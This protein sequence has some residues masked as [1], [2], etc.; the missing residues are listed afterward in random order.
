MQVDDSD[1]M[2]LSSDEDLTAQRKQR[3]GRHK[4]VCRQQRAIVARPA[5]GVGAGEGAAPSRIAVSTRFSASVR[6]HV[7]CSRWGVRPVRDFAGQGQHTTGING[8]HTQA[9]LSFSV[10]DFVL[11]GAN[12]E[13]DAESVGLVIGIAL[14]PDGHAVSTLRMYAAAPELNPAQYALKYPDCSVVHWIVQTEHV[15]E[16]AC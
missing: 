9:G 10:N 6:E 14:A 7:A 2:S 11:V 4:S 1:D 8:W 12:G 16:A 3:R 5:S 15:M 13:D